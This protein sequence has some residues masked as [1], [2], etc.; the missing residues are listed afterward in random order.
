MET[1]IM[2]FPQ[3]YV[4][5]PDVLSSISEHLSVLGISHPLVLIDPSV[6]DA[7]RKPIENDLGQQ[8]MQCRFLSFNGDSTWAEVARVKEVCIDG[9]HDAIISCGG[10][11]TLDTG[12][13]AAAGSAMNCGVVPPESME[14]LGAGVV[15]IQVPTIASTDA[16]TSRACL[17]YN[18]KG[19]FETVLFVPTN[20]A[21]ILVDTLIIS[22]APVRTFVAGM[23]D[24]LATYFEA[25]TC[26]RTKAMTPAG[27]LQTRAAHTLASLALDL[28]ITHG[29][30]AKQ[31]NEAGVV[32]PALEA[33][34]EANT[35]LSGLGFENGGLSAAHA[36]ADCLT[37]LKDRFDVPPMHGEMVSYGTVV[38]LLIG[39][40]DAASLNRVIDFCKSVDLPTTLK[41]LGLAEIS[42]QI[43][44]D[45]ANEV[46][47]NPL[48]RSMPDA[49]Q[50]PDDDGRF[51][52]PNNIFRALKTAEAR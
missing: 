1:K 11:K 8:D 10:G 45:L 4:Q 26:R 51:Y 48:I 40:K 42:D 29:L 23:G 52:D 6:I 39:G 31:E 25:D 16:S 18:D 13:A 2:V 21:M 7:C 14:D 38:H 27:G 44:W 47:K 34:V 41:D 24:A 12:R 46:S 37:P 36:I 5:G 3:R 20:P 33:V 43:L 22:K 35:L 30:K 17:I 50:A 32:G 28:L 9:G 19:A 15:C 49:G